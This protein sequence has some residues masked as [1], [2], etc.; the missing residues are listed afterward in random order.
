[1]FTATLTVTD[2][3]TPVQTVSDSVVI[4]VFL[5]LT[6]TASATPESG[7]APLS[8]AF[9]ASAGGGTS[10]YEYYWEFGD[11]DT[12]TFQNPTHVYTTPGMYTATLTVTD[13]S[14]PQQSA[15]DTITIT[16]ITPLSV[17]IS[18]SPT[19]GTAPLT[20]SFTSSVTGG[21]SPFTYAWDFGDGSAT[22]TEPNPSHTYTAE[23]T[24]TAT[25]VV[26]DSSDPSLTATDS[27]SISVSP[28]ELADD[29]PPTISILSPE[30]GT[31]VSGAVTI[32]LS[33]DDDDS[34]EG[35]VTRIEVYIDDSLL[36]TMYHMPYSCLWD[37][38]AYTDGDYII[39]AMAFDVADNFATDTITVKVNNAGVDEDEL[40]PTS[41]SCEL[42]A[43]EVTLENNLIIS[44]AITP[45]VEA[46]TVTITFTLPDNTIITH[47]TITDTNGAYTFSYI[48]TASDPLGT[49][50]VKA[51]WEG[52]DKYLGA[53]SA[54]QLFV[55]ISPELPSTTLYCEV[56][57]SSI[58]IGDSITIQGAISPPLENVL[59]T[60]TFVTPNNTIIDLEVTTST[61]G[62][63]STEFTPDY[64]GWWSVSASW[65]G[66]NE[67][68]GATSAEVSFEV[69]DKA[70]PQIISVF[71][72]PGA[73]NVSVATKIRLKFDRVMDHELTEAAITL[74]PQIA[75]SFAWEGNTLIII[76]TTPLN[77]G[78]TYEVRIGT[79]ATD[80]EHNNLLEMY[81]WSFTTEEGA[82]E[83]TDKVG[84]PERKGKEPANYWWIIGILLA[85]LIA[86]FVIL[87][88]LFRKKRKPEDEEMAEEA[89]ARPGGVQQQQQ[90]QEPPGYQGPYGADTYEFP[91]LQSY[92]QQYPSQQ[93]QPPPSSPAPSIETPYTVPSVSDAYSLEP[94]RYLPPEPSKTT[95]DLRAPAPPKAEVKPPEEPEKVSF[96]PPSGAPRER[97]KP[98]IIEP[99]ET[100]VTPPSPAETDEEA[101]RRRA[102]RKQELD[103]IFG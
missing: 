3:S 8:V 85:A 69:K 28:G 22:S 79:E 30:D 71:P 20:V 102:E 11:D 82:R 97:M 48:F 10:P 34:Y 9:T 98:R 70:G 96:E 6:A 89:M 13:A 12:S 87:F 4:S 55:V 58:T 66:N 78:T 5:P 99:P 26:T 94:P 38:T 63:Y 61:E 2:T 51:S 39:K 92:Q 100:A 16:V 1:M 27:I 7:V 45:A 17:S 15:T 19:A 56:T 46:V 18:A 24:Y 67:Y 83:P 25:L 73:T 93:L 35:T 29:T 44:G 42:T 88:L 21:V 80:A 32:E 77:Y 40:I 50:Q 52:N 74:T 75:V 54:V 64:K 49:W 103:E 81:C 59:I 76:P 91:L 101:A 53:T 68:N 37:T 14:D 84:A 90:P 33:A 95:I 86:V 31:V 72:Q 43:T 62:T 23:G 41:I 36:T 57:P 60:L 47:D 65:S